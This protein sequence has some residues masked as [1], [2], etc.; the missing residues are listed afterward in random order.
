M[1]QQTRHL[2]RQALVD[3]WTERPSA[4][5]AI[6]LRIAGGTARA[7]VPHARPAGV[8]DRI[9]LTLA[10]GCR[11]Q[12]ACRTAR[13]VAVVLTELSG[14]L[15]AMLWSVAAGGAAVLTS[16][17]RWAMAARQRRRGDRAAV[18][19]DWA[20]HPGIRVGRRRYPA[21]IPEHRRRTAGMRRSPV[22]QQFRHRR[23]CR[24]VGRRRPKRPGRRHG[25][26]GRTVTVVG[27][28]RAGRTTCP[29][30]GLLA[31]FTLSGHEPS[32]QRLTPEGDRDW[33][34]DD[35]AAV[36]CGWGDG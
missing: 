30:L 3:W 16:G 6:N 36:G 22:Q 24:V 1:R 13:E 15:G 5:W 33:D 19:I 27:R 21:L 11:W 23:G 26:D 10:R 25:P 34:A 17:V 28:G 4:L 12:Q 18:S 31:R 7:R 14:Q 32:G 20:R 29:G 8:H 35:Q 2:G 9:A